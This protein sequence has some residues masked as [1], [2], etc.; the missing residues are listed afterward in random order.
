MKMNKQS[1][2]EEFDM[3]TGNV[4]NHV[5]DRFSLVKV[6]WCHLTFVLVP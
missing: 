3:N 6:E 1:Y 5:F 4:T 2:Q